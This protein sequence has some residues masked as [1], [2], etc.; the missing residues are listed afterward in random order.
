MYKECTKQ[1]NRALTRMPTLSVQK[2]RLCT[3]L[4]HII[5][6]SILSFWFLSYYDHDNNNNNV[7]MLLCYS[8]VLQRALKITTGS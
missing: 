6:Y 2:P 8:P 4:N 7:I 3:L 1:H 5:L